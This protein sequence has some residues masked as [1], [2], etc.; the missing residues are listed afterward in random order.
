MKLKFKKIFLPTA[1]VLSTSALLATIACSNEGDK[2]AIPRNPELKLDVTNLEA[3]LQKSESTF[4]EDTDNFYTYQDGLTGLK[5]YVNKNKS[6]NKFFFSKAE[7]VEFVRTFMKEIDYGPEITAL[8]G[9][10][11]DFENE[12]VPNTAGLYIPELKQVFATTDAA[13]RNPNLTYQQR[14]AYILPTLKHEYI[15]HFA[16]IYIDRDFDSKVLDAT[17]TQATIDRTGREGY[18]KNYDKHFYDNFTKL[19]NYAN[20][21]LNKTYYDGSIK[22]GPCL[23]NYLSAAALFNI[24]NG[25]SQ[26]NAEDI[27]LFE[28]ASKDWNGQLTYDT[29]KSN[30]APNKTTEELKGTQWDPA[31][32]ERAK[33]RNYISKPLSKQGINYHYSMA[34]LIAREWT[35]LAQTSNYDQI[36]HGDT[37][38]NWF[39][40]QGYSLTGAPGPS[41]QAIADDWSRTIELRSGAVKNSVGNWESDLVIRPEGKNGKLVAANSAYGGVLKITDKNVTLDD[42]SKALYN[43]YLAAAKADNE[44]SSLTVLNPLDVHTTTSLDTSKI[45]FDKINKDSIRVGGFLTEEKA[46]K[47]KSLIVKGNYATPYVKTDLV[48]LNWDNNSKTAEDF[49]MRAKSSLL[50]MTRD[51]EPVSS[52]FS[53]EKLVTFY[54]G[55]RIDFSKAKE[56][57]FWE[58]KNSDSIVQ[59]SE[60]VKPVNKSK[61]LVTSNTSYM[62]SNYEKYAY[63]LVTDKDG[64][65]KVEKQSDLT[66]DPDS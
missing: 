58:D 37:F 45:G 25:T 30:L 60:L 13:A 26:E 4:L 44:I 27:A 35:K 40:T 42:N 17:N 41:I 3:D 49:T 9:V 48:F 38:Q 18:I 28:N 36:E 47:Y 8:N 52:N 51:L 65:V 66:S 46:K 1:A 5:F 64:I 24:S 31:S 59:E 53:S 10:V 20:T 22:Q 29:F 11:I 14:V 16:S 43:T 61:S 32:E 6:S 62:Y 33:N 63:K 21:P 19:L 23:C 57:Y 39:Y 56:L 34:E 55:A 7:I 2:P 54:A 15:H 50:S 12:I